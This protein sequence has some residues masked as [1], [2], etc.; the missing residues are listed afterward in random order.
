MKK[1]YDWIQAEYPERMSKEQMYKLCEISKR[2]A[3]YLLESGLV[4]SEN[5]G[6][7]T[8]RYSVATADV[9]KYLKARKRDP[10]RFRPPA[11]WYRDKRKMPPAAPPDVFVKLKASAAN[12]ER[13]AVWL[14]GYADALGPEAVMKITGR[15]RK[16]VNRWCREGLL[17]YFDV[18]GKLLIPKSTLIEF[19]MSKEFSGIRVA[20]E[21]E[22]K[23][24]KEIGG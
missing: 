20:R 4:P 18:R 7:K 9:V 8:H 15:E 11:N 22:K 1:G 10:A 12:R 17:Q 3:L 6:K 13:L 24:I 19:L 5:F 2:T 14:A 16:T 23:L 21:R